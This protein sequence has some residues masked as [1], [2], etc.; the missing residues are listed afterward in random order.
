MWLYD[1]TGRK[2]RIDYVSIIRILLYVCYEPESVKE[3]SKSD[4]NAIVRGT[5]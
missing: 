1:E 3:I 4:T 2:G 5:R